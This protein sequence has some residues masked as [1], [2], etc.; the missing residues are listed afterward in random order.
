MK[1]KKKIIHKI[2]VLGGLLLGVP[3]VV[4][5]FLL[6]VVLWRIGS[7]H[8]DYSEV[9]VTLQRDLDAVDQNILKHNAGINQHQEKTRELNRQITEQ[10]FQ[11]QMDFSAMEVLILLSSDPQI[12][13]AIPTQNI[14]TAY[15]SKTRSS[16]ISGMLPGIP[17]LP[18]VK[19]SATGMTAPA[20]EPKTLPPAMALP[21]PEPKTL[22]PAMQVP[23]PVAPP[24][25][26]G[27]GGA[28]EAGMSSKDAPVPAGVVVSPETIFS[29]Q[30][31][32]WLEGHD[33]SKVARLSD[34]MERFVR[35]SSLGFENRELILVAH[36]GL[37]QHRIIWSTEPQYISQQFSKIMR[38]LHQL[39][40]SENYMKSF[41]QFQKGEIP[42]RL[43]F[44]FE[45]ADEIGY[46][47][48]KY[49][50]S[51]Q[52]YFGLIPL[53][54]T[55]LS[56]GVRSPLTHEFIQSIDSIGHELNKISSGLGKS[57][58]DIRSADGK[59]TGLVRR[60][61]SSN[62][63]FRKIFIVMLLLAAFFILLTSALAIRS[64]QRG[65]VRPVLHMQEV[66]RRIEE[67]DLGQRVHVDTQDELQEL[68]ESIN[69]MLDRTVILI[70]SDEDRQRVQQDIFALLDVVSRASS[71]DLTVRGTVSTDELQAIVDAFNHM[72]NSIGVLV[73]KVRNAGMQVEQM[74]RKLLEYSRRILEKSQRQI[75]DLDIASRKIKALG[76]RS[77]EITRM[78]EQIGTIALETNTLALNASLEAAR[79]G[80]HDA[81][82]GHL[83]EHVRQLADG[84]N[85]TK[86]D[87]ESF[88]G[89]IQLATNYA[90]TSVEEV[91]HMSQQTTAEAELSYRTAEFTSA[92]ANQLG[93]AISR[94]K[95]KT[96]EDKEREQRIFHELSFVAFSLSEIRKTLRE[97]DSNE[98]ENLHSALSSFSTQ[99][100]GLGVEE[101]AFELPGVAGPIPVE[102]PAI[103]PDQKDPE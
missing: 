73:I 26:A 69:A 6:S 97:M 86:Q 84:L 15:L 94:F 22:P 49:N 40:I 54:G 55:N 52:R 50:L 36:T 64:L 37:H 80:K 30:L 96:I 58:S 29:E 16:L 9:V 82:I 100:K 25:P 38:T 67:G 24:A 7:M 75:Q 103:M 51:K 70:R 65:F 20:P 44:Q 74:S 71:G 57:D 11:Q 12:A 95:V 83:A 72:M 85:K 19:D 77:Q 56:L 10:F 98:F 91:L 47:D 14:F 87:I 46:S 23:A 17:S 88:I 60:F 18:D 102:V 101:H 78:V 62:T 45:Y 13:Y 53:L 76:D 89:S 27:A 79:S 42:V 81:G 1:N 3:L 63:G 93:E 90:V 31:R 99:L 2:T 21:A 41:Y 66:T 43:L 61:Q 4:F 48:A 39:F 33:F 28:P 34:M 32:R 5:M 8:S 68:S 59:M 35:S 92:E